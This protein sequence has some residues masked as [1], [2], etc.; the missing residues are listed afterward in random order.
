MEIIK[1]NNVTKKYGDKVILQD[2]N[3]AIPSGSFTVI[4][5]EE[6]LRQNYL[7]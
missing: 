3:L 5:G 1:L 2:L 4:M 7:T 6:R